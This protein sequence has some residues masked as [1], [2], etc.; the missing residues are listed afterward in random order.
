MANRPKGYGMTAELANKK[1][2]KFDPT[3]AQEA[4]TWIHDVLN[5]GDDGQQELAKQMEVTIT[6]QKDVQD[7][8]K[9]GVI[10]CNLINIIKPGSVRKIDTSKMSFKQMENTGNFLNACENIGVNKIDLFQTVDLFEG[11]NIPQA[12]KIF[13]GPKLGPAEATAN[14]REFTDEQLRAGEGVIGLQAGS[15]KGASQA[16]LNF[17]KTRAIID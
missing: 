2:A 3:L 14:K 9:D 8:L 15:N 11:T 7:V 16:G 4:M 17:G 5:T 13:D 12:Q 1:A 10:L 6:K